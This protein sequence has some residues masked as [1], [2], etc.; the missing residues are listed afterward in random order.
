MD[1]YRPPDENERASAVNHSGRGL[2]EPNETTE[3]NNGGSTISARAD[4][5]K[6][7]AE[8]LEFTEES[9]TRLEEALRKIHWGVVRL[10]ARI[11]TEI[12]R[13]TSD[14]SLLALSNKY[15]AGGDRDRDGGE[16]E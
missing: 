12:S 8:L 9:L 14:S 3:K 10:T 11:G 4:L 15:E 5:S 2:A 16:P 6:Y 7:D 1:I 13:L